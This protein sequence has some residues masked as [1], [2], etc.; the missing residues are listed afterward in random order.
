MEEKKDIDMQVDEAYEFLKKVS[1]KNNDI[2]SPALDSILTVLKENLD[3][4]NTSFSVEHGYNALG[5]SIMFLSQA[6]CEDEEDF[7]NE[8]QKSYNLAVNKI[9]PALQ[10]KEDDGTFDAGNSSLRRIMMALSHSIDIVLWDL[11]ASNYSEVRRRFEEEQ[12]KDK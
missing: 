9:I 4:D 1:N 3:D 6:L 2:A 5:K 7:K 12:A 10:Q 11:L 8:V